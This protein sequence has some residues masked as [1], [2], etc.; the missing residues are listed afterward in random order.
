[1]YKKTKT[2]TKEEFKYIDEVLDY[3]PNTGIIW[4]WGDEEPEFIHDIDNKYVTVSVLGRQFMAHRIAWYKELRRWPEDGMV[5]DHIDG[6][7]YNNAY[8]NLNEV[9]PGENGK[10]RFGAMRDRFRAF[11]KCMDHMAIPYEI[12]KKDTVTEVKLLHEG[13]IFVFYNMGML[14][15]IETK[16]EKNE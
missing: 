13:I 5:I 9:T 2:P 6:R 8:D 11:V 4:K 16:G 12:I 1:M 14:S 10:N 7:R 15:H 3:N